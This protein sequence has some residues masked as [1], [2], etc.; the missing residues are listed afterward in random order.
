[1]YKETLKRKK[2]MQFSVEKDFGF[3]CLSYNDPTVNDPRR[4]QIMLDRFAKVGIH[5]TIYEGVP[6][7]DERIRGRDISDGVKRLWSCTYGH[8]DMINHF[9]YKTNKTFG[10]FCED[11]VRLHKDLKTFMP[12]IGVDFQT[13]GL[14][15]LLLGYLATFKI[16]DWQAHYQLKRDVPNPWG[17]K[18]HN[19]PQDQWGVQMYMVSRPYAKFILDQFAVGYADRTLSD[20]TI[21]SFSP[22]WTISKNGNRA[23]ITPILVVEDF[24]YATEADQHDGQ[25]AFHRKCCVVNYDPALHV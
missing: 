16:A 3:Y 18:Y 21:A 5:C 2:T 1:M 25:K 17:F 6:F 8:M 24:E 7:S 9:Y 23:L 4:K 20:R 13:L 10:L 14:D 22:D 12:R 19:Y 11:D 15:I